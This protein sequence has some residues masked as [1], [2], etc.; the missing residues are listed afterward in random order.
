[1][2]KNTMVS[3]VI[4]GTISDLSPMVWRPDNA[5]LLGDI[6]I[7]NDGVMNHQAVIDL[8]SAVSQVVGKQCPQYAIYR[9]NYI[10]IHLENRDDTL[11]DNDSAANF[12]GRIEFFKPN[13][14]NINA[15]KAFRMIDKEQRK[16]ILSSTSPFWNKPTGGTRYNQPRLNW[17][18]VDQKVLPGVETSPVWDAT[19]NGEYP[20]LEPLLQLYANFQQ[21]DQPADY[22]NEVWARRT[23]LS[24]KMHWSASYKNQ[25]DAS[26]YD[27]SSQPFVW[28][29]QG[30]DLE[31]LNGLMHL[32]IEHSSTDAPDGLYDDDYTVHV[33]VGVSGWEAF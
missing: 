25:V 15:L 2:G 16:E 1:M 33:T 21:K 13:V 5:P 12:G 20:A 22:S 28:Q 14:H 31:V 4:T 17:Y 26:Q 7:D 29:S 27:P 3:H 23:G 30:N 24:Q 19:G 32:R 6:D 11:D 8:S 18:I 10:S 9:V